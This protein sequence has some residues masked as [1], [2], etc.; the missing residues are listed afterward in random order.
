MLGSSLGCFRTGK[1]RALAVAGASLPIFLA[2]GKAGL[3]LGPGSS[4]GS[5]DSEE[6]HSVL[7]LE[8]PQG[9]WTPSPS[10]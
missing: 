2:K 8:R 9:N 3:T 7:K 4:S 1:R 5:H 6:E 10:L